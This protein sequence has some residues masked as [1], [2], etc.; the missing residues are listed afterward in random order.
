MDLEFGHLDPVMVRQ[1]LDK[2][3]DGVYILDPQHRISYWNPAAERITGFTREDVHGRACRDGILVHVDAGGCRHCD[4]SCP[5]AATASD[6]EPRDLETYL[7]HKDGHRIP[8]RVSTGLLRDRQGEIAG[9]MQVFTDL[10][11]RD[12]MKEEVERYRQLAHLDDLT[13][14]ANR[15]FLTESLEAKLAE[16]RRF[17]WQLG[18]LMLD[19]D[20]FKSVNDRYGHDIGDRMLKMVAETLR[21]NVRPFD[22][23]GRWGGEE[24][25]VLLVQITP[26]KLLE[27]ANRLRNLVRSSAIPIDGEELSVTVS[28]GAAI[29]AR[30]EANAESVLRRADEMLYRSKRLG[31]DRV[32][33]D[34]DVPSS[35]LRL[36]A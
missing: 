21:S 2:V 20:H 22:T 30:Y 35:D 23:V 29:A 28:V 27:L 9:C 14:C 18:V 7:R 25:L 12:H 36:A 4:G 11:S 33:A 24:F 31:R 32:T 16:S 19:V 34:F 13:G 5:M 17:D 8:V 26:D 1:I 10:S 6:F 15:R 3:S